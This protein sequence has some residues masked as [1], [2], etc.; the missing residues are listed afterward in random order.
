LAA[1]SV[2]ASPAFAGQ[3]DTYLWIHPKFGVQRIERTTGAAVRPQSA[4]QATP[5]GGKATPWV[6]AFAVKAATTQSQ[7][8]AADRQP[9]PEAGRRVT[10]VSAN[11]ASHIA[12][13]RTPSPWRGR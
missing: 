8:L 3:G 10:Q 7:T 9:R 2:L 1:T 6:S 13:G 12:D 5:G 11:A 4:T